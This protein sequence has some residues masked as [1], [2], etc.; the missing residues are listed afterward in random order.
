MTAVQHVD[1][2][3]AA[4]PPE[5]AVAQEGGARASFDP[6]ILRRPSST[7]S[8]SS[9]PGSWPR[10]RSC[11]WSRSAACSPRSCSSGTSASRRGSENWFAGLVAAV[12]VVHRAVRQLRRGHG[13]GPGQGPGRH[14]AQG[15]GRDHG[16]RAAGRR[17]RSSRCPAR[18]C[19]SATCASSSPASSSPATARSSRAS[20]RS[21]SRPSPAS[22]PRSS[23]SR[24]ATARP[25]PA[26]PGCCPTEIVVRITAKPGETFL[27]RMIALVEGASRQKTPNE[28]ALNILLAGLTIIFL[29]ATVTLQPFAIYSGGRAADHRA[30]GAAGLPHP[31]HHRGAAL[32]HRH[33]RHGPPGAAQRAGHVGPGGRGGR[34]LLDPA[35]RQ[36]RH[37]HPRQPPGRRLR[38]GARGDARPSWPTPPSSRPWPTRRP[39][40]ARSWCWPRSATACASASWPGAELVPFTAQTRMSGVDFEGRHIRKGAA[41][42]VKRYVRRAG[43]HGPARARRRGRGHRHPGRHAAGG[44]RERPGPRRHPAQGRREAG[45]ARALRRA[46]GHGH[47]HGDDH[48]R[49]PAHRAAIAEEAGVDDFLAEAT[50]EDKMALIKK[51]QAG[52]FLVAM[53]GDGTNDAPALAQ[54]DVGV[55]MNT[56][57][58]AAKE[59]GN[60]V[61]LDSNPTKLI[62]IVEIGKQLLITRGSLTTFSIANDVAKYFAIIPAMFVGRVPGARHAQHHEAVVAQL[63][64]PLG[65][66]LQRPDHRG[67]HPAGPAGREVP[68]RRRRRRAAPQPP[69][70]RRRRPR[71]PRSSA[72]R[73]IDLVITALGVK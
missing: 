5:R 42:S 16:Q 64:D 6:A 19:R 46:A 14:A 69:H 56:G 32:G 44:G 15:P 33:R 11:S 73:L 34:R 54:A 20:P 39:R 31:D 1:A 4:R 26:A 45:H 40:A 24:V 52:G 23:A 67:A 9:T 29:L 22:R 51:E 48:R 53:T 70:L 13:R 68:G 27:D 41:D 43:R 18:S 57:T 71:S 59:A 55:A 49:Q 60:M 36:D 62:E 65:R 8:R 2:A 10:T 21:T 61:D 38:P 63:G 17:H 58:Q 25:S 50:P 35:A 72:S 66:H 12:A 3:R 37:H 28:I 30:G 47:P 7:A